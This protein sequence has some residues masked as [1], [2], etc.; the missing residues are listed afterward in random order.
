MFDELAELLDGG[1]VETL[2][3]LLKLVSS[4]SD[5][6]G[7]VSDLASGSADAQ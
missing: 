2:V 5:V 4:L 6:I 3:D 1:V 7:S